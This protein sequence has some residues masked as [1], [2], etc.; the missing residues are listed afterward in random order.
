MSTQRQKTVNEFREE[1]EELVR[2]TGE[3]SEEAKAELF[4]QYARHLLRVIRR[5]LKSAPRVRD[6]SE[7]DEFVQ[8]VAKIF[9][10]KDLPLG[11]FRSVET[12]VGFMKK[13]AENKVAEGVR[14]HLQTKKSDRNR[15]VPLESLT[16]D[17][18]PVSQEPT[19]QSVC[20]AKEK[21]ERLSRGLSAEEVYMLNL[22][23]LDLT[24]EEI[25]R[26]LKINERT[27]RR[28]VEKLKKRANRLD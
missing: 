16:E 18:H 20:E 23:G 24:H 4:N 5:K 1:L 27:V 10:S 2:R 9:F 25:A 12:F 13:V 26:N 15:Q 6:V 28:L 14:K 21:W 19:V 3:G 7:S 17:K 22:L 8:D 11:I